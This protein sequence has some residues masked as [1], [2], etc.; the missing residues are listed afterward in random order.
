MKGIR[1]IK[2]RLYKLILWLGFRVKLNDGWSDT[3]L[4]DIFENQ[5]GIRALILHPNGIFEE[6]ICWA[7]DVKFKGIVRVN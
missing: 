4:V 7:I 6:N 5:R 1:L 2:L 3:Y